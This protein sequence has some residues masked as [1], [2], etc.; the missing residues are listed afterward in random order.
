MQRT[1]DDVNRL[2]SCINDLVSVMA[3]PAMWSGQEPAQIVSTLLEALLG[4]LR[5]D[6]VYVRLKDPVGEAPVEMVRLARSP[7]LTAEPDEIGQLL[8]RQLG[9]DPRAWPTLVANPVGH[10]VLSILPL[11]L[12]LRD[13]I[14]VIVAGSQRAD[15]PV[16]T[17]RLVLRVAANQAAIGL[18]EARLLS[19]QKRV[20]VELDQ[21]VAQ[22][23]RELATA[24]EDL[25]A[26]IEERR[27][28]EDRLLYEDRKLKRSEAF[29]VAAQRLSSTGSFSW[30]VATDDITWS[31]QSYRIFDVDPAIVHPTFELM[32]TRIHPEDLAAFTELVES[33]RCNPR[34][35]E[36]QYRLQ[37]PD[38]SMK[39][40]HVVAHA[41]RDQD[42]QVEY[43]GA[44]Q[45]VTE[46][47]LSEEA[48]EK[49]RSE[50]AHV[51]RVTMLGTL[52]ASIAHEVNQPLAGIIT[53]ASTCLRMLGADPPNLDGARETVRRTL[54]DGN[55]AADVIK[56]LRALFGKKDTAAEP[57]DL[58]DATREV[59]VL[60]SSELQRGRVSVRAQLSDD[61]PPVM[62]DRVQLQQV[63][64]NLLLNASE[65]MSSVEHRPRQLL[66]RTEQDGR[67][68]VR[69]SVQDV[70]PGFDPDNQQR[71]FDAF[72][73]TKAGGMGIGLSISRSIIESHHGRLW[74]VPN[75]DGPGATFSFS[76][77]RVPEHGGSNF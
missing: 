51:A 25:K 37:M 15:F 34:D 74:A 50:L 67:E 55:R 6:F 64:M 14:G 77:P 24:N 26:E 70:G 68:C 13:E 49:L 7:N 75:D 59:L 8:N 9:L 10:G 57:V 72:Y 1:E 42:G 23:T 5:L 17:E 48:L 30:R 31:V 61:L 47:Q 62:G 65:A 18:Q 60:S 35:F 11:R 66:I 12:G 19:E 71:L 36:Y 16:K 40:I 56:R 20:A 27:R 21:R 43:I 58:N 41:T 29:L 3:L 2:Q 32:C 53:N 39:Y 45:D 4:M 63:V 33:A 22:R 69:L 44:L 46:R 52:T 54:R 76:I 73:T 38:L 28:A